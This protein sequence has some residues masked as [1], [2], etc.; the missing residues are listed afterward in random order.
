[1]D[2]DLTSAIVRFRGGQLILPSRNGPE[3][4]D[5]VVGFPIILKS[6]VCRPGMCTSP[7]CVDGKTRN[8]GDTW[9]STELYTKT[10]LS[11]GTLSPPCICVIFRER[12]KVRIVGAELLEITTSPDVQKRG[13]ISGHSEAS[14]AEYPIY[15]VQTFAASSSLLTKVVNSASRIRDSRCCEHGGRWGI[16]GDSSA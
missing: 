9:R 4:F 12:F 16:H 14:A 8:A 3:R 1:M 10:E 13:P 2:S 11:K 6:E 5:G 7:Y 15:L